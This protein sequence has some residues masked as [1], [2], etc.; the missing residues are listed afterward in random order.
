[1]TQQTLSP[2]LNVVNGQVVTN[3]LHLSEVF[4]KN[5]FHVLRDIE[6]ILKQVDDSFGKS[7]FGFSE[8]TVTNN[9]GFTVNK[10][11]YLLTRDGFTLLAMGFTGKRAL[12]FKIAYINA[13]N[14]MEQEL[15][16]QANP[17]VLS[18]REYLEI[19]DLVDGI[20]CYF[21]AKGRA[22]WAAQATLRE[23]LHIDSVLKI[24]VERRNEALLAVADLEKAASIFKRGVIEL[25]RRFFRSR[26][27]DMPAELLGEDTDAPPAQSLMTF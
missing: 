26:F 18:S 27:K 22:R 23:G 6:E 2:Q 15:I 25:E 1:M 12:E 16:A 3:S 11:M 5:H 24:P 20:E 21:H 4:D 10:P 17:P 9:L 14:A 7:N 19:R 8:Y 13:F